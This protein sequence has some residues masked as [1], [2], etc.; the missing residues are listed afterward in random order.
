[1]ALAVRYGLFVNFFW[2]LINLL[3]IQPLDGGQ[4][5]RDVL[6]PRRI[7]ITSWIGCL[8]AAVLCV[9]AIRLGMLFLAFMLAVLAYHNFQR[10]PVAGGVIKG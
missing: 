4:I 6:G 2:T 5:L 9:V 7:Q 10:Q 1:V 3:P 8:L